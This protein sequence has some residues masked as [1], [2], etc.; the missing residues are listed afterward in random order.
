MGWLK[1]LYACVV[2]VT[3]PCTRVK[4]RGGNTVAAGV[5]AESVDQNRK[6][7][8]DSRSRPGRRARQPLGGHRRN[9]W[10]GRY[11]SYP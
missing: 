3:V 4:N 8:K 9:R 2:I 11:C 7:V 10:I 1:H 6:W 5:V